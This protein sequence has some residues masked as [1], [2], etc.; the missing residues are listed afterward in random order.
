MGVRRPGCPSV[1]RAGAPQNSPRAPQCHL[2]N[3]PCKSCDRRSTDRPVPRR[4]APASA[5]T[6]PARARLHT[7]RPRWP[8][9]A[10]GPTPP[11][12][13]RAKA[14]PTCGAVPQGDV[15]S[16]RDDSHRESWHGTRAPAA[17]APPAAPQSLGP[18]AA[19]HPGPAR[20]TP[21]TPPG[22]IC[23]K[24][25]GPRYRAGPPALDRRHARWAGLPAPPVPSDPLQTKTATHAYTAPRRYVQITHRSCRHRTDSPTRRGPSRR[26][27]F[28]QQ[29][30]RTL[31]PATSPSLS[32]RERSSISFREAQSYYKTSTPWKGCP[33]S[34]TDRVES[35]V[36]TNFIIGLSNNDTRNNG[37]SSK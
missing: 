26:S 35:L 19:L 3:P 13:G 1:G 32:L 4:A 8:A 25:L 11:E 12:S 30:A 31:S 29:T 6:V 18:L 27:V 22:A 14:P 15:H 7:G 5:T 24:R 23:H 28:A 17:A 33:I 37:A 34:P 2:E 36:G 10:A 9:C 20:P 21:A 16:R